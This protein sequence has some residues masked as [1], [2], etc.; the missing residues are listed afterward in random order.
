MVEGDILSR[1]RKLRTYLSTVLLTTFLAVIVFPLTPIYGETTPGAPVPGLTIEEAVQLAFKNDP[2]TRKAELNVEQTQIARDK[3]AESITFIP[4]GG[5]VLPAYQ[6]LFNNF[7]QAEI[8]LGVAKKVQA[9]QKDLVTKN[10]IAAY[11]KAIKDKNTLDLARLSLANMQKQMAI[12]E[13]SRDLGMISSYDWQTIERGMK[14]AEEGVKAAE[15]T[16][17]SSCLALNALTGQS[18]DKTFELVSR[19]VGEQIHKNSLD[20]EYSRATND[21]VLVWRAEQMLAIEQSKQTW[22]LPNVSSDLSR[23]LLDQAQVD[24]EKAK[25]DARLTIE[26]LYYGMDAL[27]RQIQVVK[28]SNN[29]AQD[30]LRMAEVKYRVGTLPL[31]SIT[32]GQ[33]DLM[34]ARVEAEKTKA[35]LENLRADLAKLK[36]DFYYVTGRTVYESADWSTGSGTSIDLGT[37][38]NKPQTGNRISFTIGAPTYKNGNDVITLDTPA[39]IKNGRTYLPVRA[40]GESLGAQVSWDEEART[41]TLKRGDD[42]VELVIGNYNIKINGSYTTMEVV[43]EIVAGRTMLPARYVTEAFDALITWNENDQEVVIFK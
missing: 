27:E 43:P 9:T 12:R 18:K 16:Y 28:E 15:A 40:L 38:N 24:H 42:R 14:Q 23:V 30:K 8:S 25:R 6:E 13:T 11:T 1:K 3:L 32:P 20:Q 41:V 2:D 35:D 37:V 34:S 19:P 36:A 29:L 31:V 33:E 39:Y 21:A 7:Q 5:M 10:V 17:L 26:G 4:T 22:V